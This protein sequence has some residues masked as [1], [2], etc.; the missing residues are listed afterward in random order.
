MNVRRWAALASILA[1]AVAAVP[2]IAVNDR[3]LDVAPIVENGRVLVPM[4]AIFEA[5]GARLHYDATT[6]TIAADGGGHFVHLQIGNTDAIVDDRIVKLDVPARIVGTSTYV[7]MRFVAQSFGAL[8]GYDNASALVTVNLPDAV[9][10]SGST[11][12]V[13]SLVP[14]ANATIA[15]GYPTVSA[16]IGGDV[17][18][19]NATLTVDGV[20]VTDA[21]TFD[22]T[23]LTYIPSQGL[24]PGAHQVD[25]SGVD[26]A[27]VPFD[28]S[29]Q[30]TT[31]N[32]PA[33]DFGGVPFQF[34]LENGGGQFGYGD[35]MDFMLIAPP[36]GTAYLTACNSPIRM[37]M[38]GRGNRYRS[39]MRAPYGV[40]NG[41]CP[42]EAVY[43]GWNGQI[44]YA[45]V[46][47]FAQLDPYP[48]NA[49]DYNRTY[50]RG[51]YPHDRPTPRRTP[52]P[53]PAAK[54]TPAPTARPPYLPG[55]PGQ[56]PAPPIAR[57][58]HRPAP[59]PVPES[60]ATAAP[61][62]VATAAPQPQAPPR[63]PHTR[64]RP[65]QTE[66]P[67]PDPT[68]APQPAQTD[69]PAPAATSAPAPPPPPP[70]HPRPH[71]P[72]PRQ[73]PPA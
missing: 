25:V 55:P 63:T 5:L 7:P 27:N 30:F 8:V 56:T 47:I 6:H 49:Y 68:D 60:V 18:I 10:A 31:D 38:N 26:T 61:R 34:Y 9:D 45:P 21:T 52:N 11:G 72:H 13:G 53:W 69:A 43:I 46:P 36:G 33:P 23:A 4:R 2:R 29:W 32:A 66:A 14:A 17:P 15:T 67:R 58:P 22:G 39:S 62:P 64:P 73:T 28:R 65:A 35:A 48:F 24:Q 41:L 40:G 12:R 3:P 70:E 19:R 1:V 37:W 59:S 44:W 42:I 51:R 54:P 71:E 50:N 57:P 16:V 20:D